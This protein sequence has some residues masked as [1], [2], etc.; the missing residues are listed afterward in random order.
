M[1]KQ[2]G[3]N[4]LFLSLS[5]KREN[6]TALCVWL[7]GEDVTFC[8][9]NGSKLCLPYNALLTKPL[10]VCNT[11]GI[12]ALTRQILTGCNGGSHRQTHAGQVFILPKKQ[13]KTEPEANIHSWTSSSKT[14]VCRNK[15]NNSWGSLK[16]EKKNELPRQ[17]RVQKLLKKFIISWL[18]QVISISLKLPREHFHWVSFLVWWDQKASAS[19]PA[20]SCCRSRRGWARGQSQ[21]FCGN[22]PLGRCRSW[23]AF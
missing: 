17:R 2:R 21:T 22:H 12:S 7:C 11:H 16:S 13:S 5:T 8:T 4:N 10:I 1:M 9:T 23:T 20:E 14:L 6:V 19:G 15:T 3:E 18:Q